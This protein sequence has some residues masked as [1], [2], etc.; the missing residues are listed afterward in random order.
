MADHTAGISP[1]QAARIA[2]V[3]YVFIII[4]AFFA[5]FFVLNRLVVP[6]DAAAT[7]ANIASSTSL[8]RSGIV[9]F[10]AVTFADVVAAWALYLY[11]RRERRDLSLL[12]AWFR[13][14]YVALF[15][16]AL[17]CLVVALQLVDGPGTETALATGERAAQAMLFL[18]TFVYGWGIGLVCF[19]IHLLLLASMMVKSAHVPTALGVL[20]AVA[21][22]GY[23]VD[24]TARLMLPGYDS[25]SA[26][27]MAIGIVPAVIG[28][29]SFTGWLLLRGAKEREAVGTMSVPST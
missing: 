8:F 22:L 13:L 4:L 15:G 28:E 16:A 12:A 6:D 25:Y 11:F 26:L 14:V 5:N 9:A 23:I 10:L 19:G 20:L 18:D 21:G 7:V 3:T 2:G 24:N 29:F 27:F 1:P 17:L